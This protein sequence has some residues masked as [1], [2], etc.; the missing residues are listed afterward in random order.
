MEIAF[1]FPGQG[2]QHPGML[3]SLPDHPAVKSTLSQISDALGED[4]LLLDSEQALTSTTSAQLSIFA[5][6]VAVA[7]TLM[8]L[9]VSPGAVSGLSVGAYAAAVVSKALSLR[10]AV[11]LVKLRANQMEQ[12]F[13]DGYG[14]SAIVGLNQQEATAIVDPVCTD[15]TPVYVAN[16]NTAKQIVIAGKN[17]AM[18]TVLAKATALGAR[19]AERLNIV[20]P[21]H[22]PLLAPVAAQLTTALASMTLHQPEAIYISN[23]GARPLRQAQDIATDLANNIAN[24]VKWYHGNVLLAELGCTLFLEMN[25]GRVLT[26]LAGENVPAV[27]AE[28]LEFSSLRHAVKLATKATLER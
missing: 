6:G 5:A 7:G 27:R 8:E 13:H 28:A 2:S 21:S 16:I 20:V 23:I 19:R 9:G 26:D 12:M 18:D 22:C 4:V 15:E 3:H 1:L 11:T 24:T 25:P 14:M 17:E 10:D